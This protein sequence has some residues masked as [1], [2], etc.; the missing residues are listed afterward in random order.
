[1]WSNIL[2]TGEQTLNWLYLVP[3]KEEKKK[4]SVA[5]NFIEKEY[6]WHVYSHVDKVMAEVDKWMKEND[7]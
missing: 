1:M 3:W 4:R 6:M 7:F 2:F 5:S